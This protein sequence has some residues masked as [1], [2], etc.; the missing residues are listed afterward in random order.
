MVFNPKQGAS[1]TFLKD[2]I[3]LVFLKLHKNIQSNRF[4][5]KKLNVRRIYHAHLS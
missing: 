4:H 1:K 3:Y 2:A 5:R